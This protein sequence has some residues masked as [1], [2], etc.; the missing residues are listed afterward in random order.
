[1]SVQYPN[2]EAEAGLYIYTFP[3]LVQE[4]GQL[5]KIVVWSW[6]IMSPS[7][8]EAKRRFEMVARSQNR[9]ELVSSHLA[10]LLTEFV[11][12]QWLD[13]QLDEIIPECV[14]EGS[15]AVH[16]LGGHGA[17][18]GGVV[19]ITPPVTTEKDNARNEKAKADSSPVDLATMGKNILM[20]KIIDTKD[21]V[22]F[23]TNYGQFSEAERAYIHEKLA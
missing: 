21:S 17:H 19:A 15:C 13:Q 20:K 10:N 4:A 5:P 11:P 12:W 16:G 6:R 9:W 1:M 7:T 23:H 14:L 3:H 8:Q 2:W 18:A 22:L